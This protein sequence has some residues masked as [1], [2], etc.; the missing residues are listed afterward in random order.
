MLLSFFDSIGCCAEETWPSTKKK[1]H[2]NKFINNELVDS[3]LVRN[4]VEAKK[5]FIL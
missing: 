1:S 5:N 4:M 3:K 2:L